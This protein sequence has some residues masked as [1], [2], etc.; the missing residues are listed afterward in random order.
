VGDREMSQKTVQASQ[1]ISTITRKIDEKS[2]VIKDWNKAIQ[3]VFTDAEPYWIK[4]ANGKV[5]K[6]EKANRKQDAVVTVTCSVDTLQQI[7][8]NKLGSVR[9]LVTRKV[10]VDGSLNAIRELRQK[11]LG[12]THDPT[13]G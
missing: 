4:I 1:T 8:D 2:E 5:E 11:V 10:K 9:A 7:V 6:V 3:F 12:E 13:I